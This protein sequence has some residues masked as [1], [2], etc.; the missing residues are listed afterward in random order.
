MTLTLNTFIGLHPLSRSC[1]FVSVVGMELTVDWSDHQESVL[2]LKLQ[3]LTDGGDTATTDADADSADTDVDACAARTLFLD[4]PST[5]GAD[6][7][8]S[9]RN[10]MNMILHYESAIERLE[11]LWATK[12][13]I[14]PL[15]SSVCH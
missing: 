14:M 7:A 8:A 9:R 4:V 15:D 5:I 6:I 2:E 3:Q 12:V 10:L 11:D 13:S 1:A